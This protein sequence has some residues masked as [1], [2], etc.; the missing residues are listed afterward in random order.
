MK[1][2]KGQVDQRN[3]WET[4]GKLDQTTDGGKTWPKTPAGAS[5][6]LGMLGDERQCLPCIAGEGSEANIK[7]IGR[8]AY[9]L[10]IKAL[11]PFWVLHLLMPSNGQGGSRPTPP[12]RTELWV[13]VSVL[14][15]LSGAQIVT[16]RKNVQSL[17]HVRLCDPMDCSMQGS[18]VFHYL[19]KFAQ[20][21]VHWGSD[22]I[23]R[24][25]HIL[26]EK[27]LRDHPWIMSCRF[28]IAIR[29]RR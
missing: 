28:F 4:E 25:P 6:V 14:K 16:P 21:H 2:N 10:S 27:L 11:S 9:I 17:S 8:G 7:V 3:I 15:N 20:I 12:S 1:I 24:S 26:R 5:Q 23:L 18:S 13:Y 29:D 22:V 19:S